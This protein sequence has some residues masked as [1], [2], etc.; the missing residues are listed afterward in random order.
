MIYGKFDATTGKMVGR[1]QAKPNIPP[2]TN[3][4]IHKVI[5]FF[6]WDFY[7]DTVSET[8]VAKTPLTLSVPSNVIADGT[9][10][11]VISGLP[12]PCEIVWPDGFTSVVTDGE[13]RFDIDLPGLHTF[14]FF[15]LF[16]SIDKVTIEAT[17][18]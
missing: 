13:I 14:E 10:E 17:E 6:S 9:T 8:V 5:P 11:Y 7:L 12:N 16:Y 15:S 18:V 1:G 2:D 4:R 3:N